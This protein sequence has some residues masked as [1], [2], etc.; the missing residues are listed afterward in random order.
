MAYYKRMVDEQI[1]DYL[2]F[3]AVCIEGPKWC[4]KTTSANLTF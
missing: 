1:K 3:G 4:S 2:D